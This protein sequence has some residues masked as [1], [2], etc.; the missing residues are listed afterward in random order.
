MEGTSSSDA[1]HPFLFVVPDYY[2]VPSLDGPD[3]SYDPPRTNTSDLM[4]ECNTVTY[5]CA[6][7]H[8]RLSECGEFTDSRNS[9]HIQSLYGVHHLSG[10]SELYVRLNESGVFVCTDCRWVSVF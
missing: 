2:K 7:T 9:A 4:C 1:G 10:R 8:S 6:T 3:D 5:R